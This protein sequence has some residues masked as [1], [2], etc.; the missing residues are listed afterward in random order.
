MYWNNQAQQGQLRDVGDV[1]EEIDIRKLFRLLFR[2][3]FIIAGIVIPSVAAALLI[4][5]QLPLKYKGVARVIIENKVLNVMDSASVF[6]NSLNIENE[7]QVL[8]SSKLALRVVEKLNLQEVPEFNPQLQGPTGIFNPRRFLPREWADAVLGEIPEEEGVFV[9]DKKAAQMA[10]AGIFSSNLTLSLVRGT[11]ILEVIFSSKS[12]DLAAAG[13]NAIVEEYLAEKLQVK[14][15]GNKNA[16]S[17][18]ST[19]IDELKTKVENSEM[20]V[21][22]YKEEIGLAEGGGDTLY[23]KQIADVN[24]QLI[25]A[26]AK[27]LEVEVRLKHLKR[28]KASDASSDASSVT[29]GEILSSSVVQRLRLK[30]A[31]LLTKHSE[32][33]TVYGYRHP[34]MINAEAE[35]KKIKEEIKR[36]VSKIVSSLAND[37]EVSLTRE[38]SLA[39]SLEELKGEVGRFKTDE[40]KLRVLQREAAA[41]RIVFESFLKRL[42]EVNSESSFNDMNIRVVSDAQVPGSPYSPN[43][44]KIL[45]IAFVFSFGLGILMAFVMDSMESGYVSLEQVETLSGVKTV[46]IIPTVQSNG[47]NRSRPYDDIMNEPR[48][49]YGESVYSIRTSIAML[50]KDMPSKVVLVTSAEPGEGKTSFAISLAR[51]AAHYGQKVLLVDC[52]LRKP[53][54]QRVMKGARWVGLID[55]LKGDL[56]F[57]EV[58]STDV[59]GADFVTAGR[60]RGGEGNLLFNERMK[61]FIRSVKEDYDLVI[62]DSPPVLA[63]SEGLVLSRLAD[64]T[65]F[66]VKWGK[67]KRETVNLGLKKILD[68]GGH[69]EGVVLSQVDLKRYSL[70]DYGDSNAYYG[71]YYQYYGAKS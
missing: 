21:E 37:Y 42:K 53:D 27:R 23:S 1:E 29:T 5:Y 34:V 62:L 60:I 46:G 55:L 43:K 24:S 6:V 28:L 2:R 18:L 70:Y 3:K 33:S 17:W 68:K 39:E 59:S 9:A 22:R 44:K 50:E 69:L 30:E 63:V 15:E 71:K 38:S 26:R 65:L 10:A 35:L 41:D 25:S 16:S 57:D 8:N 64:Q 49:L 52:D 47:K 13:A 51:I 19:A 20:A 56:N 54:V 66:L 58:V 48:S 45:L 12:P 31:D 67:T 11:S 32:L 40:V 4:A 14:Y 61:E 7:K 36:E